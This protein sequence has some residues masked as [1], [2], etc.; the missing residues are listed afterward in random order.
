MATD[1]IELYTPLREQY[2]VTNRSNDRASNSG[3]INKFEIPSRTLIKISMPDT[4]P[5]TRLEKSEPGTAACLQAHFGARKLHN[6][7][8]TWTYAPTADGQRTYVCSYG[9]QVADICTCRCTEEPIRPA[10]MVH[11][12]E[13]RRRC[14]QRQRKHA[15][16]NDV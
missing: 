4:Q 2:N 11:Q 7:T 15:H 3:F 9:T 14:T 10:C 1:P 5:E 6:E 13:D 16:R 12:S 8:N